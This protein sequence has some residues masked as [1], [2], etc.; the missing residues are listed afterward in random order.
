[1][2]KEKSKEKK[3]TATTRKRPTA[4]TT[5]PAEK[6]N[7]SATRKRTANKST[8]PLLLDK[9]KDVADL[10]KRGTADDRITAA[11][12]CNY[13]IEN[14]NVV[15]LTADELQRIVDTFTA[16]EWISYGTNAAIR[17]TAY[18]CFKKLQHD[19][20]RYLENGRF[21]YSL[22]LTHKSARQTAEMLT[23]IIKKTP[24]QYF[25]TDVMVGL[26][27]TLYGWIVADDGTVTPDFSQDFGG[28]TFENMIE[29]ANN[30][31]RDAMAI[32]KATYTAFIRFRAR[33]EH[34][35][36]MARTDILYFHNE[37]D[38]IIDKMQR[39]YAPSAEYQEPDELFINDDEEIPK[40]CLFPSWFRMAL[41]DDKVEETYKEFDKTYMNKITEWGGIVSETTK[42]NNFN[43]GE[44]VIMPSET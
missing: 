9:Y 13:P 21:L 17:E 15:N 6:K 5:T 43:L 3:R 35:A 40:Y 41:H 24:R 32:V 19:V 7:A 28:M 8:R 18:H 29:T 42:L 25:N 1:M 30:K 4:T 44:F 23:S 33:T 2:E 10:I 31:V 36:K 37:T 20:Q 34:Y 12:L 26:A 22:I 11:T 27:P 39:S 14:L 38:S 16:D